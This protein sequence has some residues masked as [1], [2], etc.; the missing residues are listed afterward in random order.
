MTRATALPTLL[1]LRFHV[2]EESAAA[3]TVRDAKDNEYGNSIVQ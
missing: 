1:R 3:T 2:D